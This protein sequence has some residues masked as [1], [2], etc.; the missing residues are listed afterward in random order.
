MKTLNYNKTPQDPNKGSL[1][2]NLKRRE[3]LRIDIENL[4]LAKRIVSQKPVLN[5]KEL[6]KEYQKLSKTKA[7]LIKDKSLEIGSIVNS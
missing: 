3:A 1:N 6:E 2:F 4:K 7:F 5:K